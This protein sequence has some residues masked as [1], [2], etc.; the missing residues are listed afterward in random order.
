MQNKIPGNKIFSENDTSKPFLRPTFPPSK[1]GET[2][3]LFR[4]T[5]FSPFLG[6]ES[7]AC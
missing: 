1:K 4:V 3:C 6:V 7:Y 2:C 5:G